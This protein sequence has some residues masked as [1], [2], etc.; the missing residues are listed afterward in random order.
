MAVQVVGVS[1]QPEVLD[2]L[3]AL[4]TE[5]SLA[6]STMIG[7]LVCEEQ[8]RRRSKRSTPLEVVVGGV[9]YVPQRR[10]ASA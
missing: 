10:R 1:L 5:D 2:I 6:R 9:R 4:A 3:D 7:R 8:E